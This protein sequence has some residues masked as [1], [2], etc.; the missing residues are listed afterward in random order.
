MRAANYQ[1]RVGSLLPLRTCLFRASR[2]CVRIS[3][4]AGVPSAK[5]PLIE[6]SASLYAI[7]LLTKMIPTHALVQ[8]RSLGIREHPLVVADWVRVRSDGSLDITQPTGDRAP[9]IV[10]RSRTF[11]PYGRWCTMLETDSA[12]VPDGKSVRLSERDYYIV[13]PDESV[14]FVSPCTSSGE[15]PPVLYLQ[16]LIVYRGRLSHRARR[17]PRCPDGAKRGEADLRM[18][19]RSR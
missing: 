13:P 6:R 14:I 3:L 18:V 10:E 9:K 19:E 16:G 2:G 15:S 11:K 1:Q 17:D 7:S 4:T 8:V 5:Q 12:E